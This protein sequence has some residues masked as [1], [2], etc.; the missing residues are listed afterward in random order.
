M[1]V[2]II[3][4]ITDHTEAGYSLLEVLVSLVI[5]SITTAMLLPS[6]QL[7]ARPL[8]QTK[9]SAFA[10]EETRSVQQFLNNQLERLYPQPHETKANTYRF[11]GFDDELTYVSEIPEPWSAGGRALITLY[12]EQTDGQK[13]LKIAWR[14][15]HSIARHSGQNLKHDDKAMNAVLLDNIKFVKFEYY[16]DD[17][18]GSVP[19]WVSR[20]TEVKR[21]PPIIRLS[22]EF[23][24]ADRKWPP[25]VVA[26]KIDREASCVFDRAT[27]NCRERPS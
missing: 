8:N 13:A 24:D 25:L 20:W 12:T 11:E 18:T 15:L 1:A 21:L 10:H 26:P 22:I 2:H 17:L 14:P 19:G 4:S 5:L 3:E 23:E 6:F 7:L 27:Q 16:D 9:S